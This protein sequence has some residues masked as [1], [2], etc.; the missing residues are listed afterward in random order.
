MASVWTAAKSV[1]FWSK[2]NW[3]LVGA[4]ENRQQR[5]VEYRQWLATKDTR[6]REK[7]TAFTRRFGNMQALANSSNLFYKK[8]ANRLEFWMKHGS[9]TYCK[10]CKQL[11]WERLFP[12]FAKKPVIKS[13]ATCSC[14]NERY[15]IPRKK[16]IPKE[17]RDLSVSQIVALRPLDIHDGEYEKHPSGYRKKGGMFRLD[18]STDSVDTKIARLPRD[19][20]RKCRKAYDYLMNSTDSSYKSYVDRREEAISEGLR[21]NLYDYDKRNGVEC[22]LWPHLYPFTAWCET[23][24]D[25]RQSRLSSKI[26]YITKCQ[27]E[28]PDYGMSHELLHFHYDL[29]IW[30]TVTGAVATA[31]KHKCTP[32][33]ALEDKTFSPEYWRWQHRLLL[34]AVRQFGFPSLFITISPFEWSFP[35]PQWLDNLRDLTGYGPTCLPTFETTH[36]VH[37]LEQLVRGYLCGSNSNRWS[38]HVFSY[39]NQKGEKNVQTYF[40]RFEFQQRGT[41]HLHMLVWLEDIAKTNYQAIRADIPWQHPAL[42]QRVVEL[43]KA[44][45]GAIKLNNEPSQITDQNNR[46]ILNLFHPTEAFRQNLRAYIASV[47]PALK[48]HMDVQTT[49]GKG[50]VL[51]YCASYVSKWH[52]AFDSDAL[53]SVRTGPYQCAYKHL[54]GLRPLEPEMW[55]SLGMK[56]MAWSQS[57]TK[58]VSAPFPGSTFP[59]THELYCKRPNTEDHL[60]YL[61][62]L[63]LYDD[64]GKRYKEF[65]NTLVGV[66]TNSPLKDVYYFQDI[67]MNYPHRKVEELLH[68]NNDTIPEQIRHF[69]VAMD[70]RSEVWQDDEAIREHFSIAGY[71]RDYIETLISFIRSK[72]DFVRLWKRRVLGGVENIIEPVSTSETEQLTPEQIRTTALVES[73]LAKREQFYDDVNEPLTTDDQTSDAD[74]ETS[75]MSCNDDGSDNPRA[76]APQIPITNLDWRLFILIKGKPGTGKS[77]AL[78]HI[79]KR[80]LELE[81]RV[82]CVTPTGMLA[83]NYA[84][85]ISHTQFTAN[86][87]HSSFRYPVDK[88]ERPTV[89]WEIANYDLVV[90]DELSMVPENIFAHIC[91]TIRQL[92]VRPVLLLCGDPQQQQPFDTVSG[93][94][95]T[96]PNVLHNKE[97]DKNSTVVQF[98]TQHRCQ[99]PQFQELLD[100]IR[101]YRP[102]STLLKEL[103]GQRILYFNEPTDDDIF[104]VLTEMPDAI[105]L[106]VSRNAANRVNNSS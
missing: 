41:V 71:K 91:D 79:I 45:K 70:F 88:Q 22:A 78:L 6:E 23:V 94:S 95:R 72:R 1:L 15:V 62:W 64:K 104:K 32:N 31:K 63:R 74:T 26:A 38:K 20:R 2:R 92:H 19:S 59:K 61:Q 17:L 90:V 3:K 84:A 65:N 21:F 97:L 10:K 53:F 103:H 36:I 12:R 57:R 11:V 39:N 14:S 58:K 51:R 47:L 55:M 105:M 29:W 4:D 77:F 106:T 7:T 48:C 35:F 69:A 66:K 34:D 87:I 85:A 9:W 27:S 73:A 98:F 86:T 44:E 30:T 82:L 81:Y 93:K 18:W 24:L 76:I 16:D 100:N 43:Q 83:S 99:D 80:V 54:R 56:K 33:K 101:H 89:N 52:D 60:T 8:D 42:A 50:M 13:K 75:D 96:V 67:V 102:S 37:I 40:Y 68:P 49:D 5:I 25:G 28:I 46:Q